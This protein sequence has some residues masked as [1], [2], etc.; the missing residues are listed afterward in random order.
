MRCDLEGDCGIRKGDIRTSRCYAIAD[1]TK[2]EAG[3][4]RHSELQKARKLTYGCICSSP[5]QA[6][7][8]ANSCN[9]ASF[10][11]DLDFRA[12]SL[13]RRR[14]LVILQTLQYPFSTSNPTLIEYPYET[15]ARRPRKLFR[16][17]QSQ[18]R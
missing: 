7:R 4:Q 8:H 5:S 18:T 11:I 16:A 6:E 14:I 1:G 15:T 17:N 12:S 9:I 3:K 2:S 13:I 10:G